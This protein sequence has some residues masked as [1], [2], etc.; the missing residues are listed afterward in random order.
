MGDHMWRKIEKKI[1]DIELFI[2]TI[3]LFIMLCA[4]ILQVFVRIFGLN[5]MGSTEIGMLTMTFL[6]FIGTS[7]I[8]YSKD[9]IS[10]ELEQLIKNKKIVFVMNLLTNITLIIF[11]VILLFVTTTLY[12]YVLNSGEKT[13]TLGIPVSISIGTMVLGALL[14]I[15]HA[16]SDLFNLVKYKDVKMEVK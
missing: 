12:L 15:I 3:S 2:I 6:T 1:F 10:V 9:H 5:S 7:A 16:L 11:S 4:V 14:M 13:I 8:T